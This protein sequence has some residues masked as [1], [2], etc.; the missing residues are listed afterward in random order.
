MKN[1]VITKRKGTFFFDDKWKEDDTDPVYY[2]QEEMEGWIV[3]GEDHPLPRDI[4]DKAMQEGR[5]GLWTSYVREN[6]EKITHLQQQVI[7]LNQTIIQMNQQV[8][9]NNHYGP[10]PLPILTK[11]TNGW[12]T[13]CCDR[14]VQYRINNPKCKTVVCPSCKIK[15]EVKRN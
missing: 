1:R 9:V 11:G 14:S 5:N 6:D 7:Q 8:V 3:L 4:L 12:I 15:Y 2:T 10:P 13:P